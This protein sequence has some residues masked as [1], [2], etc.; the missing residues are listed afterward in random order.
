VC[1]RVR[2][3]GWVSEFYVEYERGGGVF[4]FSFL[5]WCASLEDFPFPV[6]GEMFEKWKHGGYE[7]Q[8]IYQIR[9]EGGDKPKLIKTGEIK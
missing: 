9:M 1:E 4:L 2:G 5:F 8:D 6:P 3:A 7:R